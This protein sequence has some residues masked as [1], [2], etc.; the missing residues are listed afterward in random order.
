MAPPLLKLQVNH[1]YFPTSFPYHTV[2][3]VWIFSALSWYFLG[4]TQLL[5][6]FL[7][8]FLFFP[9]ILASY[10]GAHTQPSFQ[11]P[12]PCLLSAFALSFMCLLSCLPPRVPSLRGKTWLVGCRFPPPSLFLPSLPPA[13]LSHPLLHLPSPP[14]PDIFRAG[15]I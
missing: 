11:P 5:A 1:N 7:A 10:K 3:G 13:I 14:H 12:F 9:P 4:L 2:G 6:V 8:S 15:E